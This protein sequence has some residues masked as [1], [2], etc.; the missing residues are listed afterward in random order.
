MLFESNLAIAPWWR[1]RQ[2][3]KISELTLAQTELCGGGVIDI[4][5][6]RKLDARSAPSTPRPRSKPGIF[7]S[8]P[9]NP[10]T[11]II[12]AAL[13]FIDAPAIIYPLMGK[14]FYLRASVA[15]RRL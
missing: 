2:E 11:R 12:A 8:F 14:S 13:S 6:D 5:K 10:T 1:L 7:Q 4:V 15:T 9:F 3:K